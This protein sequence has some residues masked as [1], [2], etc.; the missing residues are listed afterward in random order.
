MD[1]VFSL[2]ERYTEVGEPAGIGGVVEFRTDVYDAASIETLV[3]RLQR[4]LVAMTADPTWSVSSMDL[5]DAGE[6]VRLDE[7]G[8]RA[9]LAQ[10]ATAVSIPA[11]FAEQVARTPGRG[12]GDIRRPLDVLPRTR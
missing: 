2:A 1:L 8:N 11:V 12:G 6:Q 10:Q 4:V 9:V 7:F 3:E 5:V